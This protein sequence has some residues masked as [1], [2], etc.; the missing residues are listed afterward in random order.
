MTISYTPVSNSSK[1][2]IEF[3]TT[4][5][6]SGSGVDDF[7]SSIVVGSTEITWRDQIWT[8]ATGGGTRS[9]TIFPIVGVYDNEVTTAL[10]I[11]IK[12]RQNTANDTLVVDLG[13]CVLRVS[14]FAQ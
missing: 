3:H 6:I 7:R 10:I 12:A 13:S 2:Y 14:E 9:G 1:L 4:Y 5:A 11:K 8:N